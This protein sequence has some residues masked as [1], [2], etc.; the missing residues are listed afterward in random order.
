M[1]TGVSSSK[2]DNRWSHTSNADTDSGG[3]FWTSLYRKDSPATTAAMSSDKTI[4]KPSS[5]TKGFIDTSKRHFP[6]YI[7]HDLQTENMAHDINQSAMDAVARDMDAMGH[8][9]AEGF[10]SVASK[11]DETFGSTA[12]SDEGPDPSHYKFKR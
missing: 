6:D 3:G 12:L 1:A 2:Q 5:T 7:E 11:I 8:T 10:E 9:D 4:S